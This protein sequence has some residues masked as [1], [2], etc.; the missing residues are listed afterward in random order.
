MVNLGARNGAVL[1]Q[2]AAAQSL[3]V[4]AVV[5]CVPA[6]FS[7]V[8]RGG[9]TERPPAWFVAHALASTAGAALIL[10]HASGGQLLSTP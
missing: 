8:K 3:R 10:F 9:L 5:L 4:L 1:S 6:L 7:L 2:V